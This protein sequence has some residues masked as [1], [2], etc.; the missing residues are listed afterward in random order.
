MRKMSF[1]RF[2][3]DNILEN[4]V[5]ISDRDV[6]VMLCNNPCDSRDTTT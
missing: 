3:R 4:E 2:S 5:S 1:R 6:S